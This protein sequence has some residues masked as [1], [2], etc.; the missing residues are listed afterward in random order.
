MQFFV[1]FMEKTVEDIEI[2][3][4]VSWR[5]PQSELFSLIAFKIFNLKIAKKKK[6]KKKKKN[7]I[8]RPKIKK[9]YMDMLNGVRILRW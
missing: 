4:I 1:R 6:K 8:F 5:G 2:S 3:L 9:W 7:A